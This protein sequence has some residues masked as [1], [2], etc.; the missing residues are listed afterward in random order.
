MTRSRQRDSSDKSQKNGSR[1]QRSWGRTVFEASL[2]KAWPMGEAPP[3]LERVCLA[4]CLAFTGEQT[5]CLQGLR[6]FSE[7]KGTR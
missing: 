6:Q 1:E 3:C 4:F 7:P 2:F 5:D